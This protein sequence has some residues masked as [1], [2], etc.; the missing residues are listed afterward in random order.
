[1]RLQCKDGNQHRQELTDR[2]SG[3]SK[4]KAIQFLL[5]NKERPNKKNR[6]KLMELS[7]SLDPVFK[8]SIGR[9]ERFLAQQQLHRDAKKAKVAASAVALKTH[10]YI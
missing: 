8:S 6:E 10:I 4:K 7:D 9:V 1:M 3:G 5:E 2:L